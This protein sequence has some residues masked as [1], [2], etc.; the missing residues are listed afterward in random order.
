M[1][2]SGAEALK[3]LP[4]PAAQ[5][6][7]EFVYEDERKPRACLLVIKPDTV[8]IELRHGGPP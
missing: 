6:A 4:G 5:I 1:K 8:D 7:G 3:E 2:A